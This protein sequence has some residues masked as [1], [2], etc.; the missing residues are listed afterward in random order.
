M[1]RKDKERIKVHADRLAGVA[2]QIEAVTYDKEYKTKEEKWHQMS[3]LF[4]LLS[5]TL[6]DVEWLL[7]SFGLSKSEHELCMLRS[8]TMKEEMLEVLKKMGDKNK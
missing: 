6:I 7:D 8:I 1:N 3:I 2:L 5:D 4:K